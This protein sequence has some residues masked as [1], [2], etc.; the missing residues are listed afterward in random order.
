MLNSASKS[1]QLDYGIN[2]ILFQ[3]G[4]YPAETFESHQQYGL[5]ILMSTDAKI[6]DFLKNVLK[7]TEG[8]VYLGC[9]WRALFN[10]YK[11]CVFLLLQNGCQKMNWIR[12]VWWLPMHIPRRCSNVGSFKYKAKLVKRIP[13][14]IIQHQTKNWNVFNKKSVQWCAKYRPPSAIYRF[15]IVFAHLTFSFIRLRIANC[16]KNGTKR[17]MCPFKIHKRLNCDHSPLDCIKLIRSSTTN[18][19]HKILIIT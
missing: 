3:R 4:I 11:L 12:L 18:Y 8:M 13:I 10:Y 5:T 19:P 6:K 16:Q 7:Q 1:F 14:Q 15:W 9:N 2:S 17:M